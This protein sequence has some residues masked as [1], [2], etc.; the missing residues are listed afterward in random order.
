LSDAPCRCAR[1]NDNPHLLTPQVEVDACA[2]PDG[3]SVLGA[4]TGR[5]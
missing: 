4:F 1:S 2:P 3:N 5:D